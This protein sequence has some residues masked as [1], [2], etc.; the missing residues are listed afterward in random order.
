MNVFGLL[1][2]LLTSLNAAAREY[3]SPYH[4]KS[5]SQSGDKLRC[6]LTHRVQ[7]YGDLY[8][9]TEAGGKEYARLRVRYGLAPSHELAELSFKSSFWHP[10]TIEKKGWKFQFGRNLSEVHISG[11]QA[12]QILMALADGYIPV[13]THRDATNLREVLTAKITTTNF[14]S[15]F[16][17]Y[18]SCLADLIPISFKDLRK[19]HL[20]FESGSAKLSRD[21]T[22]LLDYVHLYSQDPDFREV[23]LFGFADSI[24]SFRANHRL[25]T[26]RV[27]SVKAY[28]V[29][30]GVAEDKIRTKVF[31]EYRPVADNRTKSGR[32]LNRRVELQLF[33]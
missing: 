17:K 2:L 32:A 19:K 6:S 1:L 25:A 29:A 4:L 12:R 9:A 20:L 33:R 28:L 10:Q 31:G 16:S 24:G 11:R 23:N 18:Q 22:L 27:E 14:G 5:W 7:G 8:F 13:I 30:K 15:N 26:D 3:I 21:S